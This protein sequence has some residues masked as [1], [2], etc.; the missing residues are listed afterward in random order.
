MYEAILNA[1]ICYGIGILLLFVVQVIGSTL[2]YLV[3]FFN[4]S[5][6]ELVASIV[7]WGIAAPAFIT[8]TLLLIQA[9]LI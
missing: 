6:G 8:G 3:G 9:F 4:L 5:V 1:G 2:N 7:G